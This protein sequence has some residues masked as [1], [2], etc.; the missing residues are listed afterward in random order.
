MLSYSIQEL[1]RSGKSS[2]VTDYRSVSWL[3]CE[4]IRETSCAGCCT[5]NSL[6]VRKAK[7]TTNPGHWVQIKENVYFFSQSARTFPQTR[8]QD[9]YTN[10]KKILLDIPKNRLLCFIWNYSTELVWFSS[11]ILHLFHQRK[12]DRADCFKKCI[13]NFI[14]NTLI[15]QGLWVSGVILILLYNIASLI[16]SKFINVYKLVLCDIHMLNMHHNQCNCHL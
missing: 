3:S 1:V 13:V 10:T 6:F 12:S 9:N 11:L 16:I 8:T 14:S 5:R 2:H 4:F 15:F 7:T